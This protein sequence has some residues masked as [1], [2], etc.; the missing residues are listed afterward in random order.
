MGI[1]VGD[2]VQDNSLRQPSAVTPQ[3]HTH[4]VHYTACAASLQD[5]PKTSHGGNSACF[6]FEKFKSKL[7][8]KPPNPPK[9]RRLTSLM[10]STLPV[11]SSSLT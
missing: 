10:R 6:D 2:C 4:A 9:T 3:A 11:L 5:N 1:A 7:N 8:P